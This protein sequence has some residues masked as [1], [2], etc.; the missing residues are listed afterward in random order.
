MHGGP[1]ANIA[2]GCSSVIATRAALRMVDYVVTEAGFGADLGAEKFVD[3]KCRE[4]G[5][6]PDAAV[7][8][9]TV[10]ALKYHGGVSVKELE[11]EDVAAVERGMAN[12][13]RHLHNIRHV[14][15]VPCVV[16]LNRFPSDTEEEIARVISLVAAEG[17]L[18]FPS[19][20]HADGGAG[21]EEL[22]KGVLELLEEPSPYTFS[23]TYPS[24][25]SLVEKME[26][27]ARRLYGAAG[28]TWDSKA[29]RR[30]ERIEARRLRAPA[31]LRGQ[32]AVLLLHRR[33]ARRRA[34]RAHRQRARGAAVRRCGLRGDAVR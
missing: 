30:V 18:A 27:V 28:V 9:A 2:H 34:L 7:V 29:R 33:R 6:R 5:L 25:L 32:D 26:T 15:G 1:F 16:A 23:F 14:Y 21:A 13:A 22:A 10:R 4:S 11:T 3:I 19:T 17:V 12:L 20:H 8:V 24:E 31:G